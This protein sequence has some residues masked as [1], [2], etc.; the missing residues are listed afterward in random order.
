MMV[1]LEFKSMSGQA[2]INRSHPIPLQP[3]TLQR[4]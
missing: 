4:P 2:E 1:R 3:P